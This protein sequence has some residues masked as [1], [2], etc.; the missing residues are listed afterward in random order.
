MGEMIGAIAHQWRQP[1]NTLGLIIQDLEEAYGFGELDE[2]YIKDTVQT[3]MKQINF[4][5]KTIDDFRN[6]FRINKK[7][8]HFSVKQA[9][10][11]TVNI[12]LAQLKHHNIKITISGDD[13]EIKGF[14]NEFKQTIL[15]II[16]NAKDMIM[17]NNI[18]NPEIQIWLKD[19]KVYISDN[20]GGIPKEIIKR[21]FEPYFTTKE[22]GKGTGMGLYMSKMI[23][24]ENMG[25]KITAH[26]KNG[27]AEFVIDFS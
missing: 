1:L 25:G 5:S 8:T 20:A 24:E 6:F 15:N 22:Q 26:N 2:K 14:D 12:V 9:I 11:E 10:Q 7:I 18:S 16:G 27:G 4:M 3:S 21:I 23:I 13:F 17:E 19:K